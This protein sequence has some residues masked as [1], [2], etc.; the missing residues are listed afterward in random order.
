MGRPSERGS[1]GRSHREAPESQATPECFKEAKV[2]APLERSRRRSSKKHFRAPSFQ[3]IVCADPAPAWDGLSLGST[4]VHNGRRDEAA[5]WMFVNFEP[6]WIPRDLD[7]PHI[8]VSV[9]TVPNRR[10]IIRNSFL[11]LEPCGR[12]ARSSPNAERR[13]RSMSPSY[14]Y[15]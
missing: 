13:T 15:F 1:S 5:E 14:L 7:V 4:W 10:L 11:H 8:P 12:H 2:G 6:L 3:N 9:E